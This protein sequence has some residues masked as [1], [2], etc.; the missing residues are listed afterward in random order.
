MS[1]RAGWR[2]ATLAAVVVLAAGCGESVKVT[3]YEPGV[4]KGAQ[5]ELLDAHAKPEQKARLQERF[6]MGQS[7]R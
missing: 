1:C 3:H 5:D 4:Y 6:T 7:E 2:A